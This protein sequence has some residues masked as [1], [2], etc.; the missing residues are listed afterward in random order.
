MI[1]LQFLIGKLNQTSRVS[2]EAAAALCAARRNHEVEPEHLLLA[3]LDSSDSDAVSIFNRYGVDFGRFS[4]DLNRSLDRLSCGNS[5]TA[6]LSSRLIRLFT[7]AWTTASLEFG[8]DTIR[9]AMLILALLETDDLREAVVRISGEFLKLNAA[10]LRV[11]W[12]AA[13]SRKE[14]IAV[15]AGSTAPTSIP[16]LDQ[17][18]VDLT[19]AARAGKID[20]VIGRENEIRQIMDILTRRRQNNP[21]LTGEAGVGKTAVVEGFAL[22]VVMGDVPPPLRKVSIRSLDLG[23]LQAGAGVRGEFEERLK[24]VI[25]EVKQSN[26]EIILFI[27]EAHTLIGGGGAAGQSDAANLLKPALARGELRTIAATT[28]SEYRRYFERDAALA[29]RFQVIKVEEPDEDR[30]VAMVRGMVPVAEKHH[31]V[32]VLDE[33][34]IAAVRLSHRYVTARQLPDKAVN[35]LD[36]AC[37]KVAL[38]QSTTP[39]ALEDCHVQIELL[40]REIGALKREA[41]FGGSHEE[42][43]SNLFNRLAVAETQLADLED[44]YKE[45]RKLVHRII[46]LRNELE[47]DPAPQRGR[48]ARMELDGVAQQLTEAQGDSPLIQPF[49][50]GRAVAEVI[51]AWTGIPV[52]QMVRDELNTV[53]NLHNL[54]GA[55]VVGQ[56][57]ALEAIARRVRTARAGLED[58][59]RPTGVFLLAG[60]SG[61]GKTETALA[62]ADVLYGG[63]RNAVVINMSEY[64]EAHSV[65]GLKGSP[66]GYVGYG[67]GGVL[68]EAV[69]RRPYCVLL[70]DEMEKA[71][72]DVMELFYQVF[73]KGRM[74]DSQGREVDFRNTIILI[75]SNTGSGTIQALCAKPNDL[76]DLETLRGALGSEL[77]AVFKPALLGRMLVVPYYPISGNVL[78]Q[79]IELKLD[80]IGK[81]LENTYRI[82][83]Q[84]SDA[85]VEHIGNRCV[86]VENGARN[87]DQILTGALLPEISRRLL[88]ATSTQSNFRRI[89]VDMSPSGA[90]RYIME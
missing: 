56:N 69:R 52:G 31:N 12:E 9:S 48:D 20:P 28:Y 42:R 25:S 88:T 65:S 49:V 19:A 44:R 26:E 71:H 45:E 24:S 63:E 50:D 67:E 60:P 36:T 33:A 87:V 51:S 3:V 23:L 27:D 15:V 59:N 83:F 61:V 6:S 29:R 39:P 57:Q 1:N 89:S 34:V 4:T 81:R 46:Q 53:L 90:I 62:L 14:G 64:Q 76:P 74:E 30:A 2:T 70:L 84:Y 47:S 35:V 21:I 10:R 54:L 43:L 80:K 68:T 55:R 17:F 37:A 11:E 22:R 40:E 16:S 78:R 66:P 13:L 77:R 72:P 86:E 38:G 75:T 82:S 32:R 85:L 58:P 41:E 79:I 5:G 7:S 73:D 18:T 8:C